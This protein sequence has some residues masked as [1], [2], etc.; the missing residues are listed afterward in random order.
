MKKNKSPE[1]RR[2]EQRFWEKGLLPTLC[3]KTRDRKV[4]I[5]GVGNPLCGDD[6]L[7]PGLVARLQGRVRAILIDAEDVPENYLGPITIAQPEVVLIVDAVD[8]GA[9]P[10]EVALI[11]ASQ[12]AGTRISTHN[13]SLALFAQWVEAET[14]AQ[15]L[16]LAV[17][18]ETVEFGVMMSPEVAITLE[19]L[20]DLFLYL[21]D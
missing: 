17:Q 2:G 18:P 6:G 3:Q 5:L 10:G 20:E 7:G 21:F 11:S 19:G 14:G 9:K 8:M 16:L 15:V 4:L 1:T 12:I 13:S